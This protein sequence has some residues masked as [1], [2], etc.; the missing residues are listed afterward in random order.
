ME[1][2]PR[3][4]KFLRLTIPSQPAEPKRRLASGGVLRFQI[5]R[6]RWLKTMNGLLRIL[7]K[8]MMVLAMNKRLALI[9]YY[10][11]H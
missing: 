2:A 8:W 1:A 10:K 6:W 3:K 5:Q 7:R 4:M 11:L 9:T